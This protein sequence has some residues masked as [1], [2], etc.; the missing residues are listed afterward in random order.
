VIEAMVDGPD[1]DAV[2]ED[3]EGLFDPEQALVGESRRSG[4]VS[5]SLT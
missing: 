3:A 5:W 1:I 2:L 4:V